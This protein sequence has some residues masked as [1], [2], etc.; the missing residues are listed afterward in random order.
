MTTPI[1]SATIEIHGAHTDRDRE[2]IARYLDRVCGWPDCV[3]DVDAVDGVAGLFGFNDFTVTDGAVTSY[4][5]WD[6]LPGA[7]AVFKRWVDA[8][9]TWKAALDE[10]HDGLTYGSDTHSSIS[11]G[12]MDY[13]RAEVI[14]IL[15][16][17]HKVQREALRWFLGSA[18]PDFTGS[19][20][21]P[22][23]KYAVIG[24]TLNG[25]I[26]LRPHEQ[27][28]AARPTTGS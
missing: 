9:D 28:V 16:I 21:G 27:H 18:G 2:L 26:D 12:A 25:M 13:M 22:A 14:Q 17:T 1:D 6:G 15:D 24:D 5:E 19:M 3:S 7:T 23:H 10:L 8:L 11:E 4:S 20:G